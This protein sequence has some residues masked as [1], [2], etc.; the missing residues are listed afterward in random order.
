ML[1]VGDRDP[2]K[3]IAHWMTSWFDLLGSGRLEEAC[4]QLDLPA[5]DGEAWTPARLTAELEDIFGPGTRYRLTY[6]EGPRFTPA[7]RATGRTYA[8]VTKLTDGSGFS[9]DHAVPLNGAFSD[10]SAEFEF[11]WSGKGLLVALYQLHVQ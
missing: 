6:P 9:A 3:D 7:S 5:G 2:E 8:L 1:T 11:R 10:L 4:E